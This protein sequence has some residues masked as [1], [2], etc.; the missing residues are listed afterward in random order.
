MSFVYLIAASGA[1]RGN[2]FQ[3][4]YCDTKLEHGG[5]AINS[6]LVD[7]GTKVYLHSNHPS[8]TLNILTAMAF[9]GTNWTKQAQQSWAPSALLANGQRNFVLMGFDENYV[10]TLSSSLGNNK[11]EDCAMMLWDEASLGIPQKDKEIKKNHYGLNRNCVHPNIIQN[12]SNAGEIYFN[13]ITEYYEASD[14]Y[15]G[16]IRMLINANNYQ[17]KQFSGLGK[18]TQ[19]K[20]I[21]NKQFSITSAFNPTI[22]EWY[23]M[24]TLTADM[25]NVLIYYNW[26][27]SKATYWELPTHDNKLHRHSKITGLSS[28]G[29]LPVTGLYAGH[30]N[31]LYTTNKC[32]EPLFGE[33]A[34]SSRCFFVQNKYRSGHITSL[35]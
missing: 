6:S 28:G 17:T 2:P 23:A 33:T 31:K 16:F 20:R 19:E 12:P 11:N 32:N 18:K 14:P 7:N 22:N 21:D 26:N 1:K 25:V 3:L 34:G 35:E 27:D 13:T 30:T 10:I 24:G 8:S 15:T 5:V 4:D 9:D 29:G